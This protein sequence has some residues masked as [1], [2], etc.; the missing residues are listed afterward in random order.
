VSDFPDGTG[1]TRFDRT[2]RQ[3]FQALRNRNFRLFFIGQLISNTGN[4][5]TSVALVLL[6]LHLTNN[7]GLAAGA[8]AACQFGPMLFLSA[9]AGAIADRSDK[10]RMLLWTQSLEMAE[11]VGLAVL[12]FMPHPPL[13]GLYALAFFGGVLLSFDNPLR[14]SFVSEMVPPEDIPNA[15]VLYSL[16]VNTSRM[17]GPALAGL[18]VVTLGYGW[19]FT[20]DAATYLVVLACLV[21]MRPAELHRQPPR[22]REK[23]EIRE[24]LRYVASTPVLW[25]SFVM[26]TAIGMLAYNFNTTLPLFVTLGLHSN[27]SVYTVLLSVFALGAVVTALV[28]ANKALIR[29][30]HII[31]GAG[32]LGSSMLLLAS[33][34]GLGFAIPAAFL[35]GGAS[36][37][38]MTATTAII[39]VEGKRE[40]HGRVLALQMVVVGGGGFIGG[41]LSGWLADTLGGR[42]PI[43][44]GGVACLLAAGFGYYANR[45]YARRTAAEPGR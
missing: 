30:R 31:I 29:M 27:A 12:A 34:P 10:R 22:A 16:I 19:G 1:G 43:I 38:Y 40:M 18:L 8:L 36:I 7:S 13:A 4:W 20:I 33:T 35:V 9:W 21:G 5:L 3:T 11:S 2:L 32:A 24:G 39:Q 25:I 6:V 17:I 28:V 41:P 42:A 45:R 14:R 15:V 26:L 23:G 37:L 44:L